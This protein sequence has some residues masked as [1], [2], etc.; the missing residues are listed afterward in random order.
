MRSNASRLIWRNAVIKPLPE[1]DPEIQEKILILRNHP[2]VCEMSHQSKP[3]R[4]EEHLEF[5]QRLRLPLEQAEYDCCAI[6]CGAVNKISSK[7]YRKQKV[8]PPNSG[9]SQLRPIVGVISIN[10]KT[11]GVPLLGLYKNLY[12]YQKISMGRYLLLAGMLRALDLGFKQIYL[13]CYPENAIMQYLA[14][15]NGFFREETRAPILRFQR[16][17]PSRQE[18]FEQFPI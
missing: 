12:H 16:I 15:N 7:E 8:P 14:V 5:L 17:L 11:P 13:E 4:F 1:L 10:C 18:L 3:I 6:Y 9:L 2:D